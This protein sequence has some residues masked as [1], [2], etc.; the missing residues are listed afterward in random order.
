MTRR[1][2]RRLRSDR[3]GAPRRYL[4]A[5]H[6]RRFAYDR[7]STNAADARCINDNLQRTHGPATHGCR[8][9]RCDA[10]HKRSA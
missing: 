7:R 10:T 3:R 5:R 6:E 9:E 1:H 2:A 8:C 4:T